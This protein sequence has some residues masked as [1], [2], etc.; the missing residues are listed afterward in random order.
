MQV[1]GSIG[2]ESK[3][4]KKLQLTSAISATVNFNFGGDGFIDKENPTDKD[5]EL[6]LEEAKRLYGAKAVYSQYED[7]ANVSIQ[8][9][10]RTVAVQ[11]FAGKLQEE[12]AQDEANTWKLGVIAR[13]SSPEAR[14]E[15]VKKT[16]SSLPLAERQALLASLQAE[17]AAELGQN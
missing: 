16:V 11:I 10:V 17:I 13:R 5:Y 4:G 9:R 2:P 1:T 12:K 8:Q 6:A 15:K 14:K 3:V 7:G